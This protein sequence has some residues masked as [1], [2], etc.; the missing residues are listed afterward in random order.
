MDPEDPEEFY[1]ESVK[2]VKHNVVD[3]DPPPTTYIEAAFQQIPQLH[4]RLT[5]FARMCA[6]CRVPAG[7]ELNK[8]I[9]EALHGE[10]RRQMLKGP[11]ASYRL[12]DTSS[13]P[14]FVPDDPGTDDDTVATFHTASNVSFN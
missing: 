12:V 10:A 6:Q 5:D 2:A 9:K 8:R 13:L 11:N 4:A 3:V 14:S 1:L 7:R